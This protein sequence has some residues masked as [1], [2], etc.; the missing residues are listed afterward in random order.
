MRHKNGEIR[1]GYQ[2]MAVEDPLP[3]ANLTK[4]SLRTSRL[5]EFFYESL[6]ERDL[7]LA[8]P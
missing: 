4:K 5:P 1:A 3:C 8:V 7:P 6:I 2:F